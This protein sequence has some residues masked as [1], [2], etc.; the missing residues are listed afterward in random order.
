MTTS[1]TTVNGVKYVVKLDKPN[2][3]IIDAHVKG[4]LYLT[5]TADA[6]DREGEGW[7]VICRHSTNLR[8]KHTDT[9]GRIASSLPSNV[10]QCVRAFAQ[11]VDK[12]L[13]KDGRRMMHEA[14]I[15]HQ[16]QNLPNEL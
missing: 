7:H 11:Y 16:V 3:I 1:E 10:E 4:R 8:Y 12:Q 6:P 2:R 15:R 9:D 5:A 13:E 14:S